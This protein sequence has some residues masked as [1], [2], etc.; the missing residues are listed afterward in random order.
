[1]SSKKGRPP[2]EDSRD[3]QYRIRLTDEELRK[4]DFC[5]EKTGLSKADVIRRGIE[6]VYQEIIK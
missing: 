5:C 2:K 1:M 6:A 3:N 4:L